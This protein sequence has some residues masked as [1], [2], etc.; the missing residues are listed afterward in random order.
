MIEVG[1]YYFLIEVLLGSII[2][3]KEHTFQYFA[4]FFKLILNLFLINTRNYVN[5]ALSFGRFVPPGLLEC[6]LQFT[7]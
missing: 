4:L 6:S 5:L 2:T 1:F 7:C 3:Q